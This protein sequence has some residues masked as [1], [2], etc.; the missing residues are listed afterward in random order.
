MMV[1]T[2]MHLECVVSM[3]GWAIKHRTTNHDLPFYPTPSYDHLC[4]VPP[5][6]PHQEL[7]NN[8]LQDGSLVPQGKNLALFNVKESRDTRNQSENCKT[9]PKIKR[10]KLT[11]SRL[12]L[13]PL[14][15][16]V[17]LSLFSNV[18]QVPPSRTPPAWLSKV[19]Q[20]FNRRHRRS[21]S[22]LTP[23]LLG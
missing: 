14:R 5:C 20:C 10:F 18:S 13:P 6:L 4:A 21:D 15:L 11:S 9:K 12:L 1:C 17:V 8:N 22:I 3:H 7:G 23:T 16:V 2:S 19:N